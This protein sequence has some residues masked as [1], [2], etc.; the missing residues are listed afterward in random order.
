MQPFCLCI[1]RKKILTKARTNLSELDSNHYAEQK[2]K[3][4]EGEIK[5]IKVDDHKSNG[6]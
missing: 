4:T 2:K 3:K 6:D 5:L 1:T